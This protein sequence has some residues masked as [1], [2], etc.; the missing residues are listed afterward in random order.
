MKEGLLKEHPFAAGID[1]GDTEIVVAI[2][3]N[4]E[5]YEVRTFGTFSEDLDNIVFH[6]QENGIT[7]AAMES[8]GVYYVP[9]V[10]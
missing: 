6:L 8:T 2:R 9:P 1:I 10:S 3:V 7:T 5:G 4:E